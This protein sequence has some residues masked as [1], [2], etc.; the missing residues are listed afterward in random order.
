MIPESLSVSGVHVGSPSYPVHGDTRESASSP[1]S[2]PPPTYTPGDT[3]EQNR[4]P[5]SALV[6]Q[7]IATEKPGR[8]GVKAT[9]LS[10]CS[11][12]LTSTR[13]PLYYHCT[14]TVP[15]S[16]PFRPLPQLHDQ[17]TTTAIPR[18]L[19]YHHYPPYDHDTTTALPRHSLT[20]T[21]PFTTTALPRVLSYHHAAP[22]P[23]L[24]YH[25][26]TTV[27]L[28]PPPALHHH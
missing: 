6:L 21:Q 11:S 19:S 26:T 13:R 14:T 25:S 18:F 10:C 12:S 27:S 5:F 9:L 23:P 17:Y 15:L 24:R 22:S 20:T 2:P 8:R 1:P 4:V 7:K 16:P 28:L 3:R